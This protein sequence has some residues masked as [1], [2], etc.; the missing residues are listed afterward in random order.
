M[1][2]HTKKDQLLAR[3]Y[4]YFAEHGFKQADNISTLT[5]SVGISRSLFYFY[6]KDTEDLLTQLSALHRARV[7]QRYERVLD[8][9]RSFIEYLHHT[10]Y[11]KDIYFMTV[12]SARYVQEHP[13]Y[14]EMLNVVVESVDEYNFKQFIKHYQLEGLSERAVRMIYASFRNHWFA[15]SVYHEWTIERVD[16]LISQVDEMVT[17]L[18]AERSAQ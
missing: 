5:K 11:Q 7:Q 2:Q 4:Q 10:V 15:N 14:A 13:R 3:L 17:L 6:F 8:E 12:Q 9:E 18:R 1:A 16:E